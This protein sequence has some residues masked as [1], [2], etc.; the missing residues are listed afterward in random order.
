M[1]TLLVTAV[2]TLSLAVVF[3]MA[4]G[5]GPLFKAKTIKTL[6]PVGLHTPDHPTKIRKVAFYVS[7]LSQQQGVA[8]NTTSADYEKQH[9]LLLVNEMPPPGQAGSSSIYAVHGDGTGKTLLTRSGAMPSWTP[10]GKIIFI[11]N[12]SGSQQIW[13]MDADGSNARQMGNV[14]SKMPLM[15]QIARN[16]LIVFMGA[17]KA[18]TQPGADGNVGIWIMRQDGSGLRACLKRHSGP[19]PLGS[20]AQTLSL[21][22]RYTEPS[23]D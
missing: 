16:G 5:N 7:P 12:R 13:M 22:R 6:I 15:P 9:T 3:A 14:Q 4:Q 18:E 17:D 1:K 21:G 20:H 8:A 19:V 23:I 2:G 11:S 10:D